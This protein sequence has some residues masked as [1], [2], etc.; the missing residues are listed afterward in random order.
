LIAICLILG[1]S[2]LASI[3]IGLYFL[4]PMNLVQRNFLHCPRHTFAVKREK[5]E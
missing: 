4:Y 2:M 1:F 5:I 3:R